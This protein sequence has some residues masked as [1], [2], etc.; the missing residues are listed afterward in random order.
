MMPNSSGRNWGSGFG[1]QRTHQYVPTVR[2][3]TVDADHTA[4]Q[5]ETPPG[6]ESDATVQRS[7]GPARAHL[8]HLPTLSFWRYHL[9]QEPDVVVPHVRICGGVRGNLDPYFDYA[10]SIQLAPPSALRRWSGTHFV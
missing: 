9:T 4:T 5:S 1:Q 2:G 7:V 10:R 3:P 6:H 8:P